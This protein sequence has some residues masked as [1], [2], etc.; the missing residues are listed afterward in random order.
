MTK[1]S[2]ENSFFCLVLIELLN[3][4]AAR[5]R[6]EMKTQ[7]IQRELGSSLFIFEVMGLQYF[8]LKSMKDG[9]DR[10]TILRS[11][12]MLCL[13]A[14]VLFM[15]INFIMSDKDIS[16]ERLNVKNVLMFA[17]Q[18][19]MHVCLIMVVCI[20]IVQ[21]FVTTKCTMQFYHNANKLKQLY[22]EEFKLV[23][24]FTIIKKSVLKRL[25][26]TLL[27]FGVIHGSEIVFRLRSF[28]D[29]VPMF[30]GAIPVL[31]LLMIAFKFV[32]Y[33]DFVNNQ[34]R[35]LENLIKNIARPQPLKTVDNISYHLLHVKVMSI[36]YDDL[37]IKLSSARKYYNIIYENG[38]LVNDTNGLTVLILLIDSVV[39]MTLAGYQSFVVIVGGMPLARL[40]GKFSY[41]NNNS[42]T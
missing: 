8:S 42:I 13:L 18:R 33:V 9:K 24:D 6:S 38:K 23:V 29:I 36:S 1:F 16:S 41:S 5:K 40:S 22:F 39:A 31:F 20:S 17:V 15:M 32:L 7:N 10:P 3:L 35:S 30:M 11:I 27:F 37:L 28:N 2:H 19:S 12:Y 25:L 26:A 21:S 34:L 14:I 4:K